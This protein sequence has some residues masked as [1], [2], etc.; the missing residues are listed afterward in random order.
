M[1]MYFCILVRAAIVETWFV[2]VFSRW[3]Y[4]GVQMQ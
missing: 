1:T 3:G 2:L 4:K